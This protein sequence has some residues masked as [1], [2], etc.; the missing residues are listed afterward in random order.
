MKGHHVTFKLANMCTTQYIVYLSRLHVP[1]GRIAR[2]S[3]NGDL[4][5]DTG[6]DVDDDLLDDL[7]RGVEASRLAHVTNSRRYTYSMRR[8]WMRI[9]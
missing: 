5:L 6:I 8:L 2:L 1:S 9:S 4:D 7:S 3:G